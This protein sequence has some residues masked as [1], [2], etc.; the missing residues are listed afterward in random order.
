MEI[1]STYGATNLQKEY[2]MDG[3][4][5]DGDITLSGFV[6]EEG[7]NKPLSDMYIGA[8]RVKHISSPLYDHIN[9]DALVQTDENGRFL[10][11]ILESTPDLDRVFVFVSSPYFSH[12]NKIYK[13]A[14]FIKKI[15]SMEDLLSTDIVEIDLT[16]DAEINF[17]LSP[18]PDRELALRKL[19]YMYPLYAKAKDLNMNISEDEYYFG[20]SLYEIVEGGDYNRALEFADKA[21]ILLKEKGEI[22]LDRW[23]Q[24]MKSDIV[25]GPYLE[26]PCEGDGF[27]SDDNVVLTYYFYWYDVYSCMH[28]KYACR[29]DALQDHPVTLQGFSY[30]MVEWHKKELQDMIDAGIDVVLPVYW[31]VPGYYKEWSFT[32]LEKLVQAELELINEGKKPP[33][34]GMFY[35]TSSMGLW[36]ERH[37]IKPDLTTDVGKEWFYLTIRDFFSRVPKKLWATIDDKPIVWLYTSSQATTYDQTTFEHV[38]SRFLE[39]FNQSLYIVRERSWDKPKNSEDKRDIVTENVYRWGAALNGPYFDGVAAIGP[40]FDNTAVFYRPFPRIR[41]RDGFYEDSWQKAIASDLNMVVIETWNELHEGTDIC[42]TKEYGR[43]YIELTRKYVGKFHVNV[44]VTRPERGNLYIFDR[45]ILELSSEDTLIIG[46]ITV[47]VDAYSKEGIEHVEFYIDDELRYVDE[48]YPYEW[49]WDEFAIGSYEIKAIAYDDKG[50]GS[51]D[52]LKVIIFNI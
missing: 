9:V 33:K 22:I 17:V 48:E 11:E 14:E 26:E 29:V 47:E 8:S 28:V 4:T 12:Q 21:M 44:S 25:P 39:D 5:R 42:E 10:F 16:K 51:T 40:G 3:E 32:G 27:S 50:R 7:S 35:D 23:F 6:L 30:K 36:I 18:T 31:G 46:K 37:D 13:D 2:P 20:E 34:I 19:L 38:Y 49:L 1:A 52:E 41:R 43:E 24:E 45:A 15:P